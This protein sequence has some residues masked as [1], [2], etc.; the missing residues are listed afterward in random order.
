MKDIFSWKVRSHLPAFHP[1]LGNIQICID[2][3]R[4]KR[5]TLRKKC[6]ILR[7]QVMTAIDYILCGLSISCAGLDISCNQSCTG[8]LHQLFPVRIFTYQ[9]IAG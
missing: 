8:Q 1:K 6:T 4:C 3:S 7:N 5:C 9:F 2:N